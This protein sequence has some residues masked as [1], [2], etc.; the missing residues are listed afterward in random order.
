MHNV[1]GDGNGRML[2]ISCYIE[3]ESNK[4][5]VIVIRCC[6]ADPQRRVQSTVTT[7]VTK[8]QV[9]IF[10]MW[11]HSHFGKMEMVLQT[12]LSWTQSSRQN[13]ASGKH[14]RQT[15]QWE[16]RLCSASGLCLRSWMMFNCGRCRWWKSEDLWPCTSCWISLVLEWLIICSH[17]QVAEWSSP[18]V[19]S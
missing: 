16:G 17:V 2:W 8:P 10:K 18:V 7:A 11:N 19:K 13:T 6:H 14:R 3:K 12:S 9:L 5:K 1:P 4:K 15:P